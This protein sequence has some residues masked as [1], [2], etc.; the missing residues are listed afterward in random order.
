MK[1]SLR[2]SHRKIWMVLGIA[3]PLA[4]L[5]GLFL[6]QTV[7]LDRPAVLVEPAKE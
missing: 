2:R 4:L 1:R 3:L 5:A 7:P 6:K